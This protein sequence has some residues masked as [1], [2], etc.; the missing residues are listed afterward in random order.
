MRIFLVLYFC[1]TDVVVASLLC[2]EVMTKGEN[3]EGEKY[4]FSNRICFLCYKK[5]GGMERSCFWESQRF[6][7]VPQQTKKELYAQ[8]LLLDAELSLL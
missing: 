3:F 4:L 5:F 1:S 6:M 7:T 2:R 8:Q